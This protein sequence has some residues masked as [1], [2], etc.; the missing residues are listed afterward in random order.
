LVEEHAEIVAAI[1]SGDRSRALAVMDEHMHD[2][3]GRLTPAPA[4]DA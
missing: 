4:P 1:R 3:V 2:A